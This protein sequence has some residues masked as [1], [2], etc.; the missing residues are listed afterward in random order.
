MVT[1]SG[2]YPEKY[3]ERLCN[4]WFES[5][6]DEGVKI[7]H[8]GTTQKLKSYNVWWTSLNIVATSEVKIYN[9]L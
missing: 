2:G 1:V 7:I 5:H 9:R 4:S 6:F 8:A 3:E